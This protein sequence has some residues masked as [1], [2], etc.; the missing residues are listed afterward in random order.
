MLLQFRELV[1]GRGYPLSVII[2]FN[3]VVRAEDHSHQ[4]LFV[5]CFVWL[6]ESYAS[7]ALLVGLLWYMKC[8]SPL[9]YWSKLHDVCSRKICVTPLKV[10]P[11]FLPAISNSSMCSAISSLFTR[12][13]TYS[14]YRSVLSIVMK[15][16]KKKDINFLYE[17]WQQ[18][19]TLQLKMTGQKCFTI[20]IIGA[21]SYVTSCCWDR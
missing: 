13:L 2:G 3:Q 9:W 12:V 8:T 17:F 21:I 4:F 20:C 5:V 7:L 15:W 11:Q 10:Q 18:P 16:W 6:L 1:R 14:L 19:I